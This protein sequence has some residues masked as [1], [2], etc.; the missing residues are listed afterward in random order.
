MKR[1]EMYTGD[2]VTDA[3]RHQQYLDETYPIKDGVVTFT[4]DVSIRVE[5]RDEEE[6]KEEARNVI[7]M[8]M[9]DHRVWDYDIGR[10][11]LEEL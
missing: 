5:G 4:V 10:I 3:E 6:W 9:K 7:K 1:M 11:E 2:P 8:L